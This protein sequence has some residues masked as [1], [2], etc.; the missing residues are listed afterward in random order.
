[1]ENGHKND[2]LYK[3]SSLGKRMFAS[4]VAAKAA[5][6]VPG[7]TR[8][9]LYRPSPECDEIYRIIQIYVHKNAGL[10]DTSPNTVGLGSS[11]EDQWDGFVSCH[12]REDAKWK[13]DNPGLLWR[14]FVDFSPLCVP[15]AIALYPDPI[16]GKW[17]PNPLRS[18]EEADA[19]FAKLNADRE[20][21]SLPLYTWV[22]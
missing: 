13:I 3:H 15:W 20:V 6:M 2:F 14:Y 17:F 11:I 4:D 18:Q 9:G 7:E 8:F 10:I 5:I 12:L 22:Q 1:V 16:S 21:K 19:I